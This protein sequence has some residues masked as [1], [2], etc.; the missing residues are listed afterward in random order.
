MIRE[1]DL[2][3]HTERA[4]LFD[5]EKLG[6][7]P[8][9]GPYGSVYTQYKVRQVVDVRNLVDVRRYHV[10]CTQRII[11]PNPNP[12]VLAIPATST[13]TVNGYYNYP[14][15]LQSTFSLGLSGH[16][17]RLI[18]YS[19]RTVNTTVSASNSE[20]MGL[21]ATASVQ[22]T[23]GSSTSDTNSFGISLSEMFGLGGDFGHSSTSDQYHSTTN[24]SEQGS[25]AEYGE[26]DSMSIKDWA[27]FAY[28]SPDGNTPTWV[29]GQQYPWDTIQYR[30]PNDAP[31]V[32]PLGTVS[33]PTF[34]QR[35]L[36]SNDPYVM[37]PS[38]LSLFGI[39]FTMKAAWLVD[40]PDGSTSDDM[41]VTHSVEYLAASHFTNGS[42]IFTQFNMPVV[43]STP[44]PAT[45]SL[46]LLGLDPIRN[47]SVRNGAVIGFIPSKFVAPPSD[48]G[49][50]KIISEA[51]TLQIT[52]NGFYLIPAFGANLQAAGKATLKVQFKIMDTGNDY[53]IFMKH[54]VTTGNGCKLEFVFNGRETVTRHIDW[55]EGEGGEDNLTSVVMRNRDY[56]SIDY[57]DYLVMG[58]N[59]IDI[60][61]TPNDGATFYSLRALAIG[62]Q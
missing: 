13:P 15:V 29:W 19:P 57:H 35:R 7:K 51:N 11:I 54:W 25:S 6:E 26:N 36:M 3:T 5:N 61:I 47:G 52:G 45:L 17:A 34:V 18:K 8:P 62:E 39:D 9:Y 49:E 4:L 59:T 48:G 14:A 2:Y 38:Q 23:S 28:V 40:L 22:N 10:A 37:P 33:V 46:T 32:W 56:T 60:T 12:F 50:F 58:L 55:G 30:D 31:D 16:K 21:T 1:S 42:M 20:N 44:P 27:S 41:T 43:K 24:G 53:A